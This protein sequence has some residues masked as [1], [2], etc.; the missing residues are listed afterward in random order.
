MLVLWIGA[1]A[2]PLGLFGLQ[3]ITPEVST[4]QSKSQER[5]PA[6][7]TWV[8]YLS[9]RGLTKRGDFMSF[10][11]FLAQAVLVSLSGVMAPGPMSA[12]AVG[13][14]SNSPRA[15]LWISV[16]HG[17]VEVPLMI[18]LL[19]G[20]GKL[21]QI[22]TV[23][24]FIACVGGVFLFLMAAGMLR[25]A[26]AKKL[27]SK[28]DARSPLVIGIAASAGNPYFLLWWATVG[29]TLLVETKLYGIPGFVAFA[30]VHW[31]CDFA[32]L[33]LLSFLAYR[34]SKLLGGTFER[35]VY[36]VCGIVL[37]FFGGKFLIDGFGGI[38]GLM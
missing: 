13:K 4:V 12:V 8:R 37:A 11:L 36:G 7:P 30:L 1:V 34:G 33:G 19:M 35:S 38:L 3:G 9:E 32:W 24:S 2:T 6:L 5:A 17:I 10:I 29:M 14:G 15:G 25:D 22:T 16:G 28:S 26:G 27:K 23:K 18:A 21:V 20:F 31:A